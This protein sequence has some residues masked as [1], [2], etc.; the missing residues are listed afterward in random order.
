MSG[1]RRVD[2]RLD[3]EASELTA[4]DDIA[5]ERKVARNGLVL[6][7]LGF[8]QVAHEANKNGHFVGVSRYRDRLDTVI[9]G[10][11]VFGDTPVA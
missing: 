11:L 5:K 3:L 4:I 8:L 2:I 9:V 6:Q 1:R 10:N 7:A